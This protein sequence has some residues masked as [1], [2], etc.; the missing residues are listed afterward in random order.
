ML[1]RILTIFPDFFGGP[2]DYGIIRRA[3]EAGLVRLGIKKSN[4]NGDETITRV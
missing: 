2:L 4:G 3:K 1:F